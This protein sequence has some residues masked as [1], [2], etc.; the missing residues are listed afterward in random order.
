MGNIARRKDCVPARLTVRINLDISTLVEIHYASKKFRVW[1][2]ANANKYRI[3]RF[4]P[5]PTGKRVLE[6]DRLDPL[7][8]IYLQQSYIRYKFD[9]SELLCVCLKLLARRRA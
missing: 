4:V 5:Y 7:A 8:A 9:V 6:N 2:N 1:L 3:D